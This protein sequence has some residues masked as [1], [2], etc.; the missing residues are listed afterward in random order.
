MQFR[1]YFSWRV[2]E[3]SVRCDV[4]QSDDDRVVRRSADNY[5]PLTSCNRTS[6]VVF[7]EFR[8]HVA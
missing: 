8:H 1:A 4:P 5:T 3:T 2:I 6:D 7:Q